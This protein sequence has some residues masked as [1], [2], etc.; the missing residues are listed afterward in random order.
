M[1]EDSANGSLVIYE[2]RDAGNSWS[3]KSVLDTRVWHSA[4][5]AVLVQNGCVYM[6]ME[7]QS[8]SA[9][10]AGYSDNAAL[11]PI[12]LR[13][14]AD[15]DLT[16]KE[17]WTFSSELA[18]G[19]ILKH[20]AAA[21]V[22]YV[23][24]PNSYG[25]PKKVGWAA[26]NVFQVHDETSSWYDPSMKTF[27]IYLHGS[28]GAQ[29][30]ALLLKVTENARGEMK[31][32]LVTAPKS[33]KIL[34][35]VPMSG[36]NDRFS[37]IYDPATELYWM[38]CSYMN[39][40]ERIGLYFSRNAYDWCFAGFAAKADEGACTSPSLTVDGNDLLVAAQSGANGQII[41]CRVKDYAKI[42]Y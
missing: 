18:Y 38:A 11:A 19:D 5:S 6:T 20:G 37:M 42:V 7:V 13:A 9:V 8:A 4:P 14:S 23:D 16:K 32:S 3:T 15:S 22:D 25:D 26:G 27:Y 1:G 12:L 40:D 30:Y 10:A 17:S 21:A 34:L 39:R 35:F 28:E 31:P 36:G 24:V 2:S 33:N 41:V 29:G